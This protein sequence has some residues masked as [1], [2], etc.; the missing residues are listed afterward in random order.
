MG[1]D[2]IT[3]EVRMEK[4][5]LE[6]LQHHVGIEEDSGSILGTSV[7]TVNNPAL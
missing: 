2:K 5:K 6:A 1:L 7:N 3:L 4:S